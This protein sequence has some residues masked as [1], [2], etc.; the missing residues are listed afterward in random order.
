MALGVFGNR[1]GHMCLAAVQRFGPSIFAL[2]PDSAV[3]VRQGERPMVRVAPMLLTSYDDDAMR[4][5]IVTR[6][7]APQGVQRQVMVR[8]VD[9][10]T[11]TDFRVKGLHR[12]R[13]FTKVSV[14]VT[15]LSGRVKGRQVGRVAL[16]RTPLATTAAP[17]PARTAAPRVERAAF[18]ALVRDLASRADRD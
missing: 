5:R 13:S 4:V 11:A 9:P 8:T 6:L 2:N 18:R 3:W 10:E 15:A 1:R 16:A 14:R 7:T 17:A 12:I